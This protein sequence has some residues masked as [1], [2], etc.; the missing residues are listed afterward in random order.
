MKTPKVKNKILL[1][2]LL[3]LFSLFLIACE[4]EEVRESE[5]TIHPDIDDKAEEAL[6]SVFSDVTDLRETGDNEYEVFS[7]D[8]S[9][10]YV[11][12]VEVLGHVDDIRLLVSFDELADTRQVN[13]VVIIEH[14]ESPGLGARIEEEE[15]ISQFRDTTEE[16]LALAEDGGE[17]DRIT[18]S[19]QSSSA[20]VRGVRQ[21]LDEQEIED[22]QDSVHHP[23]ESTIEK[24]FPRFTNFEEV[25]D[26]KYEVFDEDMMLGHVKVVEVQGH[27]D[28]IVLL[29][30]LD[31]TGILEDFVIIEQDE[32]P[33]RFA[34]IEEEKDEFKQQF[35][36]LSVEE[37]ELDEEGGEIDA[38]TGA[39]RT[40][41]AIV[42][43]VRK[44]FNNE[45]E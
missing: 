14:D 24:I 16:D 36:N 3:I 7:E 31:E 23:D 40:S 4:T 19:T 2:L 39:T 26:G 45:D 34:K 33:E 42:E 29:V 38:V 10:G 22:A 43:G 13:E 8:T 6:R 18:G 25:S 37:I 9:L 12:F 28:E 41:E 30:G 27:R 32:T 44:A 20:V 15:F 17:I 5:Q 35:E 1:V 21:I 11:S